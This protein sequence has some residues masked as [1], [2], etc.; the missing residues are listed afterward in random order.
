MSFGLTNVLRTF[1]RLMD[2]VLR[3]Y[4]SKLV[5]VYYNILIYNKSL[6]EHN[7]LMSF[8]IIL[9]EHHLFAKL[10]KCTFYKE[11]VVFIGFKVGKDDIHVDPSSPPLKM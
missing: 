4:T 10:D 1:M 2:Y 8:L 6:G 5:I 11:N 9:R 7:H 3:Y